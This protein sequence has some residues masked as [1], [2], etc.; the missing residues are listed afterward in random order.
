MNELARDLT[1]LF[2]QRKNAKD[3]QS[4]D[5]LLF[6]R[7]ALIWYDGEIE[8]SSDRYKAFK[9]KVFAVIE[10]LAKNSS[11]LIDDWPAEIS[12]IDECH[13]ESEGVTALD[14]LDWQDI[15]RHQ[16]NGGTRFG[17]AKNIREQLNSK[18]FRLNM[19][20][21]VEKNQRSILNRAEK[22]FKESDAV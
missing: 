4:I 10:K 8:P 13:L 16:F 18:D 21:A 11:S 22:R 12:E 19:A 3:I 1:N 5:E 17:V 9:K 6:K 20:R 15:T 14:G 2:E 7:H